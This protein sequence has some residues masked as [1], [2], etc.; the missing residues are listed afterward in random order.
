[1]HIGAYGNIAHS[2]GLRHTV[3]ES[4]AG[5]RGTGAT[6]TTD[7]HP[8]VVPASDDRRPII[9]ASLKRQG[10]PNAPL[11]SVSGLLHHAPSFSVPTPTA[12]L[13][14]SRVARK[15]RH[16]GG[17]IDPGLRDRQR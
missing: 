3:I 12:R 13:I 6:S 15:V 17:K 1:M 14:R 2:V 10:I 7:D 11:L 16:R 8:A 5:L 4:T 9:Q